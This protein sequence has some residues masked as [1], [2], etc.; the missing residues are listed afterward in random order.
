MKQVLDVPGAL[1]VADQ[2]QLARHAQF[3][4]LRTDSTPTVSVAKS[5]APAARM[6]ASVRCQCARSLP[7]ALD[8]GGDARLGA[9]AV[10]AREHPLGEA[11]VHAQ[12]RIAQPGARDRLPRTLDGELLDARAQPVEADA[13]ADL[14]IHARGLGDA[15]AVAGGD[16]HDVERGIQRLEA[17]ERAASGGGRPASR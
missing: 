2:D 17:R 8:P 1:A 12:R 3:A 15:D 14:E 5:P 6:S 11:P 9:A 7:A 4:S 10:L 16:L 13:R